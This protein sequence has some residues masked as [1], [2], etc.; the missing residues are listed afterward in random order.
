MNPWFTYNKMLPAGVV[1]FSHACHDCVL[2]C[3]V[4]RSVTPR[5]LGACAGKA[6]D[7]ILVALSGWLWSSHFSIHTFGMTNVT[8]V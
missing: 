1:C 4:V 5:Q 7:V 3:Q 8:G 6:T 2:P